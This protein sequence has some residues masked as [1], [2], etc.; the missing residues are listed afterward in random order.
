MALKVEVVFITPRMA[1]EWLAKSEGNPRWRNKAKRTDDVVVATIA[2]DIEMGLWNPGNNSIAFDENGVLVDGHHRLSAII[3]CGI[4]VECVVVCGVTENGKSHIDDNRKRTDTQRSGIGTRV[5]AVPPIHLAMLKNS[6]GSARTM[7][8][9]QKLK[10]IKLHPAVFEAARIASGGAS[11]K[12]ARR[13]GIIHAYMCAIEYGLS[14]TCLTRF[15]KCVNT[16][17]IEGNEES[18]AIILRNHLLGKKAVSG[19]GVRL[20]E[21]QF[22]QMALYDFANGTPR[23]LAYKNARGRFF[24]MNAARG[25]KYY[26]SLF[27]GYE[28]EA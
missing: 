14:E 23:R 3:R 12:L 1:A 11:G 13:S 5:I 19:D 26:T 15:N 8:Y 25:N 27:G 7:S 10:W 6:P 20:L 21:S 17:F 22:A 18:A 24:D 4:G 9:E 2:R 16:G 28:D